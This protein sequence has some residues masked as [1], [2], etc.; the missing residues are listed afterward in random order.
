MILDEMYV[1]DILTGADDIADAIEVQ[2]QLTELLQVGGF[3]IHKWCTSHP[4]SLN[5]VAAED[6]EEL[7]KRAI[8]ANET[9]RTL[10]LE[11][12]PNSDLFQFSVGKAESANTKR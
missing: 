8:D 2:G 7:S 9:I 1:D 5:H 12:D 10:G 11:W 3:E 6:R 4:E